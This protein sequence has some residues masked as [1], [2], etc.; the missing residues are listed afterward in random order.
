MF[1]DSLRKTG[2]FWY[3]FCAASVRA[4]ATGRRPQRWRIS[5]VCGWGSEN[6]W[7]T[8]AG[9][10][11]FTWCAG[12]DLG[13]RDD[14]IGH[15]LILQ[16]STRARWLPR[17]RVNVHKGWSLVNTAVVWKHRVLRTVPALV[18]LKASGELTK[19]APFPVNSFKLGAK[20]ISFAS[21]RLRL[22]GVCSTKSVQFV[23]RRNGICCQLQR[24]SK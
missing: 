4:R 18:R 10:D 21:L 11:W 8:S 14:L 19:P 1:S 17:L 12:F 15:P 5:Q 13:P 3:A 24:V 16:L 22:R 23:W 20:E 7:R 6:R 2:P 9:G